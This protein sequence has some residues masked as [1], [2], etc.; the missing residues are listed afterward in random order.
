MGVELLAPYRTKK[1]DPAPERSAIFLSRLRYRI[2]TASSL[3]SRSAI[4]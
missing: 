1:R 4:A 2:D 3:S